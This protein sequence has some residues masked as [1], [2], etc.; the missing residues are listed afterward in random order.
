MDRCTLC[1]QQD[2]SCEDCKKAYKKPERINT[3]NEFSELDNSLLK[4]L[5]KMDIKKVEKAKKLADSIKTRTEQMVRYYKVIDTLQQDNI[6][7]LQELETYW[8][9]KYQS[10]K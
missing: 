9:E 4:L 8:V 5:R 6:K 2:K 3:I 1:W 7:D 10:K